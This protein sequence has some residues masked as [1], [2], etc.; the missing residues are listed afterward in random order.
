MS[1]LIWSEWKPEC[2]DCGLGRREEV[3][4]LLAGRKRMQRLDL[5]AFYCFSWLSNIGI[6]V[7]L[8]SQRKFGKL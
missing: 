2:G 1:V 4:C 6:F 7:P 3:I 8:I 5:E